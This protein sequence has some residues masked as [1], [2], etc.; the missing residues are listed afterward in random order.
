MGKIN[1]AIEQRLRFIDFLLYTYGFINRKIICDYF[2][3]CS[4]TASKDFKMY[5]DIAPTNM[6]YN[7]SEKTYYK[8]NSFKKVY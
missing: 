2:G 4:A 1:Y 3:V 8:T 6:L 5:K 7:L